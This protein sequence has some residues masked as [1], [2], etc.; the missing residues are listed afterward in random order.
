MSY[1]L[2][3][4]SKYQSH[5]AKNIISFEI[6]GHILEAYKHTM[7]P[8][9]CHIY[10]TASVM[11]MVTMR[12]FT[13]VHHV[14][15]NWK[16]VLRCCDKCTNIVIPSQESNG[17]TTITCPTINFNV[18]RNISFYTLN[19]RRTYKEQTICSMCSTVPMAD[20]AK[21]LYTRKELV[22]LETY[23]TE[24]NEKFYITSIRNWHLIFHM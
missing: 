5:N 22:S 24:F 13:Y 20:T 14:L 8:N 11:A 7:R 18:C 15:Y 23:I 9:F 16:C 19:V 4:K 21:K 2:Y 6:T 10:K 3:E 12:P 1:L 17:D